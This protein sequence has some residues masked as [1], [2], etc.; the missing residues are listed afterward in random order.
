MESIRK[1]LKENQW[2]QSE[3]EPESLHATDRSHAPSWV[4]GP[5]S[6]VSPRPVLLPTRQED[7]PLPPPPPL[8]R[9]Q[10]AEK[11]CLV[12]ARRFVLYDRSSLALAKPDS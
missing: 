6:W 11:A 5:S 2:L 10:H 4:A 7:Q 3:R 8:C 9:R 1:R 12:H